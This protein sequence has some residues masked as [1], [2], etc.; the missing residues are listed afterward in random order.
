MFIDTDSSI[1]KSGGFTYLI[2]A[3]KSAKYEKHA[4]WVGFSGPWRQMT[5]QMASEPTANPEWEQ[6][7]PCQATTQQKRQNSVAYKD[8]LSE[9]CVA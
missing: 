1:L 9:S 7:A 4:G 5:F 2:Q 8:W 3:E 6:L